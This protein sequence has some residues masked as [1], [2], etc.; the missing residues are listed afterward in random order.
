MRLMRRTL[1]P[2]P[3]SGYAVGMFTRML[4]ARVYCVLMVALVAG[5]CEN[6]GGGMTMPPKPTDTPADVADP[7]W[8]FWPAQMHIHPLT[9]ISTDR[10]TGATVL[11]A[12][13]EFLDQYG[14]T[15]RGFGQIRL[16]LSDQA[17]AVPSAFTDV[18]SIDLRLLERNRTHFDDVTRTY[19]FKLKLDQQQIPARPELRAYFYGSDG[20]TLKD[21][22]TVRPYVIEPVEETEPAKDTAAPDEQQDS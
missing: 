13:I 1:Q 7:R 9:R 21:R 20:A 10:S 4:S 14:T 8:P 6:G 5:G 22:R 11:E 19:L 12:R 16:E 17:G 3:G 2:R 15:T 18:W